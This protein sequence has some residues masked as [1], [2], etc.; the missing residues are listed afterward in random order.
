MALK[1]PFSELDWQLT[2]EPVR[3]YIMALERTLFDMEQRIALHEKRLEKL[4]VRT[5]KNS[6]NSSK[7]PSSDPPFA[8][9]KRKQKKSKKA[10]GGQKGHKPHQQ[11][12]LD[13]TESYWLTPQ[14]CSCGHSAF[15][16]EKMKTFYVH[17][18]IELPEIEMQVNHYLLQQCDC[19][20][21][22]NVVKAMLPPEMSTG[23]GPRFTAFIGE[24][25]GIK[26]MSRNDVKKL[27]ESVLDIPIATG[28]IQKIVDRTSNALLPVYE[29]IG[30]IA[31]RFW[32]NYI[33]ETSW[34]KQNDLHWLWAMVNERVA[35]YRIDPHRS[36]AAF[37]NLIQDWNGI[38]VSDGYGLYQKWVHRQT[39]L[40]HLIRKADALTERKKPDLRR[41]GEIVAAW[42][43][44]LVSF[45]KEPPD[46]KQWS[47][48]YTFFLFT[49]SL[50]EEDK[51]D[52]GRLARQIVREMDSLW[53]FLDHHGVEPTNN[54]AERALR[55]GV[56][57]R[58]RSLGTQSEKGNR[59]VERILSL[60]ETCRLNEKPTFP[61][62]VECI[63]SYFRNIMPD[64]SWI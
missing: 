63:A 14:R 3:H 8:R 49:V 55:F 11:Q 37:E 60:K 56:L 47:D 54:R 18:H 30:Q 44:Q 38:L 4:E 64:L 53:T 39:C 19:P 45:A 17:Q 33:D 46:S 22:G 58:K 32:C 43:R 6:H 23:Y 10:K 9:K 1:R 12:V 35:F 59:W 36:K 25:S 15:D 2:P 20:N 42:L 41:F 48:F 57:W 40:A 34:F 52:A 26:G 62:L 5:R 51:T 16:Q 7:P 13:P 50:W 29:R 28:T 61:F 21:C 27:C 24:L 31:R